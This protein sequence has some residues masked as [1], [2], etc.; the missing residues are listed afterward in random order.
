MIEAGHA[1]RPGDLDVC[2]MPT[3]RDACGPRVEGGGERRDEGPSR[4]GSTSD[5]PA[6]G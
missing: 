1:E 5:Q 2:S 3:G 4:G 6:A